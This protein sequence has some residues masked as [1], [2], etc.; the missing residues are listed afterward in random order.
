MTKTAD[1]KT[2]SKKRINGAKKGKKFERDVAN[3]LLH[4]FPEAQRMLEYQASKVI[5]ADLENTD[6][7]K[8]QCKRNQGYA[9]IS[10]IKEVQIKHE[11]DIPL[12]VTKGNNM[13]AMAVLPFEKFVELLEVVYGLAPHWGEKKDL[14]EVK[15]EGTGLGLIDAPKGCSALPHHNEDDLFTNTMTAYVKKATEIVKEK[16]EEKERDP[17]NPSLSDFL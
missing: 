13:D 1:S 12:L 9:P 11:N 2:S 4:I 8:I 10:R 14:I 15:N 16:A 5:G 3:A 6:C 17:Y 7:F